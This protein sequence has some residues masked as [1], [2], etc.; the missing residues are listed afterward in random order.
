MD[1]FI[2]TKMKVL[3]NTEDPVYKYQIIK[4]GLVASFSKYLLEKEI[5]K[6]IV[7]PSL[8]RSTKCHDILAYLK[9][10]TAVL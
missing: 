6:L 10:L 5:D 2:S 9:E 8:L 7:N 4:L 3:L 1:R